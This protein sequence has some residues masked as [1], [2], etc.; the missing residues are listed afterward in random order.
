[1]DGLVELK[2]GTY[3]IKVDICPGTDEQIEAIE[4]FIQATPE[5]RARLLSLGMVTSSVLAQIMPTIRAVGESVRHE[6]S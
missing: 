1:M 5:E 4:D 6:A 3:T 2:E